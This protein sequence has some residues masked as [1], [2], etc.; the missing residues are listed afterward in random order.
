MSVLSTR[1]FEIESCQGG[2]E[3]VQEYNLYF[4]LWWTEY[5]NSLKIDIKKYCIWHYSNSQ[6]QYWICSFYLDF[7]NQCWPYFYWIYLKDIVVLPSK[8]FKDT[9]VSSYFSSEKSG[10]LFQNIICWLWET[11]EGESQ[12]GEFENIF[13]VDHHPTHQCWLT[14]RPQ[15][16]HHIP[17]IAGYYLIIIWSSYIW[18]NIIYNITCLPASRVG[19]KLL[20]F[21]GCRDCD[22]PGLL[23]YPARSRYILNIIATSYFNKIFLNLKQAFKFPCNLK[24]IL[25]KFKL[26]ISLK[27]VG[28]VYFRK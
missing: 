21:L 25:K 1:I 23:F 15:L 24:I 3:D 14:D 12:S 10:A 13:R 9:K 17:D 26:A 7:L 6:H 22:A 4:R 5:F 11:R 2:K 20:C 27:Q 18:K 28:L 16:V 8:S 19:T